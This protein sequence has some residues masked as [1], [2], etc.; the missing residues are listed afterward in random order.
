MALSACAGMRSYPTGLRADQS[1]VF[2]AHL[3]AVA[4]KRNMQYSD[5]NHSLNVRTEKGDWLQFMTKK[6]VIELVIIPEVEGLNDA[7]IA[8][9]QEEL[10]K[11]GDE[12]IAEAKQQAESSKA[13]DVKN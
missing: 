9:R 7:Q 13:F 5:H 2:Y 11:L 8:E 10:R 12:L 1:P 4:E 6:D 3:K